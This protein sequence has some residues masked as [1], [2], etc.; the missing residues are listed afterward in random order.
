MSQVGNAVVERCANRNYHYGNRRVRRLIEKLETANLETP[1]SGAA[2]AGNGE[3]NRD[4]DKGLQAESAG[5]RENE[6]AG[7]ATTF[8]VSPNLSMSWRANMYL[9]GAVAVVCLGT[10]IV[11]AFFGFWVVLPFAGAEVIFVTWCLHTTVRKLSV[12]EVITISENEI[13]VEWGRTGPQQSVKLPRHWT[14]LAYS[15]SENPFEVG[16]L[17]VCAYGKSYALGSSL[18]RSEKHELFTELNKLI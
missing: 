12:K 1:A 14:R 18:G 6:S 8:V 11:W 2:G 13:K 7:P 9:A 4:N 3:R 17:M 15:C 5:P 16:D 10:A